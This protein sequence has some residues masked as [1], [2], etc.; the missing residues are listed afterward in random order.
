[1][2]HSLEPQPRDSRLETFSAAASNMIALEKGL[3]WTAISKIRAL[4]AQQH[5]TEDQLAEC[6][7]RIAEGGSALGRVGRYEQIFL[8]RLNADLIKIRGAVLSPQMAQELIRSGTVEYQISVPR[9][10]QLLDHV[11][12]QHRLQQVSAADARN[13]IRAII[14]QRFESSDPQRGDFENEIVA[15][16][17]N[18]GINADDVRELLNSVVEARNRLKAG[19]Q[20]RLVAVTGSILIAVGLA[21]AGCWLWPNTQTTASLPQPAHQPIATPNAIEIKGAGTETIDQPTE[22]SQ[23]AG[24]QSTENPSVS[25]GRPSKLDI[26]DLLKVS[27]PAL[28]SRFEKWQARFVELLDQDFEPPLPDNRAAAFADRQKKRKALD[29]LAFEPST[30]RIQIRALD[31]LSVLAQRIDDLTP[32]EAKSIASFCFRR[33]NQALEVAIVRVAKQFGRW[34]NFL[35]AV[36][37]AFGNQDRLRSTGEWNQRFAFAITDGKLKKDENLSASFFAL[38]R[39][40]L[41]ELLLQHEQARVGKK[42]KVEGDFVKHLRQ[43]I[44]D[45][46]NDRQH[47]RYF[48]RL[49]DARDLG[50]PSMRRQIELQQILIEA[51][52][53]AKPDDVSL[54]VGETHFSRLNS[55]ATL[56]EQLTYSRQ[57]AMRLVNRH[58]QWLKQTGSTATVTRQ[59]TV[60]LSAAKARRLRDEAETAALSGDVA[61]MANAVA[62]YEA[63]IDCG[64]T[65]TI[66]SCLRGLIAIAKNPLDLNRYHRQLDFVN[67]GQR[68][69]LSKFAGATVDGQPTQKDWQ[70]II[71]RCRQLRRSIAPQ[72]QSEKPAN[73]DA[74]PD[75]DVINSALGWLAD[76]GPPLSMF[77]LDLLLRIEAQAPVKMKSIQAS[78]LRIQLPSPIQATIPSVEVTPLVPLRR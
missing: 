10:Q 74:N 78:L 25:A 20:R 44:S 67:G 14:G 64:D 32:E 69:P 3:T 37:D 49:I 2:D 35:L 47:G 53:F 26:D 70:S 61:Q 45:N 9:A 77:E 21:I 62:T 40:R 4:A 31:D 16:G 52:L 50:Q 39:L 22:D 27:H 46:V 68:G 65:A 23:N 72:E 33:H 19:R 76:R 58:L 29:A 8:D 30:E 7:D 11:A 51:L 36:S 6:L 42:T 34:P 60:G 56:G 17:A 1:M 18:F 66:R 63:A 24:V 75:A 13:R 71:M 73:A 38:A 54:S 48:N 12:T 59:Q 15:H 55:A 28:V 41:Q 5:L 57:S 43:F